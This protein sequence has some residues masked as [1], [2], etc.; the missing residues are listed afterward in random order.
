MKTDH[1]GFGLISLFLL[2][3]VTTQPIEA[4]SSADEYLL[5]GFSLTGGRMSFNKALV[6]DWNESTEIWLDQSKSYFSFGVGYDYLERNSWIGAGANVRYGST[7]LDPFALRPNPSIGFS[8]KDISYSFLLFDGAFYIVPVTE[9]P[10]AFTLGFSLGTSFH[11]YTIS[12]DDPYVPVG[13]EENFTIF[14]YG[15]ILGCKI[16]P[17]RL[18]SFELEYRPMAA[19][20]QTTTYELGDFAYTKDNLNYYWAKEIGSSSGMSESMFLMSLSIH[21]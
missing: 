17:L 8:Y 9:L 10:F 18:V 12:S 16:M 13:G 21:F 11:G 4:Q 14:R 3:L 2:I 1:F 15:Y 7:T 6:M 5:R 20:S 19:Y